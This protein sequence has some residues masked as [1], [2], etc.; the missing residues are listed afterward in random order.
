LK[1][2][3]TI[4]L[5]LLGVTAGL[6]GARHV[7]AASGSFSFTFAGEATLPVSAK[8]SFPCNGGAV[9]LVAPF[10]AAY[11]CPTTGT[12]SF[13]TAAASGDPGEAAETPP[14]NTPAAQ[15]VHG[16]LNDTVDGDPQVNCLPNDPVP[17]VMTASFTYTEPCPSPPPPGL[18]PQG[19]A[20][21][22]FT[23]SRGAVAF[24]SGTFAWVRNGTNAAITVTSVTMDNGPAPGTATG[25]GSGTANF[26]PDLPLGTCQA[27][28]AAN[29]YADV[30][31]GSVAGTI[32]TS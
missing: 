6:V 32:S 30:T 18:P 13:T 7:G 12:A 15:F 21:G 9:V 28:N 10:P 27:P 24:F 23:V 4:L 19:G 5:A 29:Q 26:V 25:S 17:C 31:N 22:S 2:R 11:G 20:V 1:K 16:T 8:P 14:D 3:V